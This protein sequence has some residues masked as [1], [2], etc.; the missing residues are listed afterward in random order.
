MTDNV[1]YW[2]LQIWSDKR[3]G[4]W[5]CAI[6]KRKKSD[7][8][9]VATFIDAT[10][11]LMWMSDKSL[12]EVWAHLMKLKRLGRLEF[13]FTQENERLMSDLIKRESPSSWR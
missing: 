4:F 13:S 7:E 8:K 1:E 6:Y 5:D 3:S 2:L 12:R 11:R 9:G 10:P